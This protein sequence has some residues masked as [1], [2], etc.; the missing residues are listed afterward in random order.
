MARRVS[1]SQFRS[2]LNRLKQQTR[3]AEQKQRQ[4]LSRF[5]F[6]V[7]AYNR[8]ARA[9]N[10]R[11]RANRQRLNRELA[12]L[13]ARPAAT[14]TYVAYRSSVHVMRQSF[15][16]VESAAEAGAWADDRD[17]LD[18]AEGETA[19]SVAT[20]NV[21][22]GD[23]T[24]PEA[25]AASLQ[26]TVLTSELADIGRDLD[27]RWRGALFALSP[28][29]PDAARHF[30]TSAREIITTILDDA[31]PDAAVQASN[32]DCVKTPNGTVSRRAKILYCLEQQGDPNDALA[33]FVDDDIDSVVALFNDFNKGT[34]G[35]TGSFGLAQLLAIK[36][37]VE[38]AIQFI[39]R[40]V[41]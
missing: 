7:N 39:H 22:E 10:A 14:T 15:A 21:L 32:P 41:R 27:A 33:E 38:A 28:E 8:E 5:N 25:D 19:N 30:C 13:K 18:L 3:Q 16:R 6:A 1:P 37:R 23:E 29:N 40:I 11:V 4:A 17:L 9:H 20:L 2:Q 12:K 24:D 35:H 36:T 31:A 26:T 34:H